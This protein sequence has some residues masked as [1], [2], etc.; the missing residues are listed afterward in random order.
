M[1]L[2]KD[3]FKVYKTFL[4]QFRDASKPRSSHSLSTVLSFNRQRVLL[5]SSMMVFVHALLALGGL[6]VPSAHSGTNLNGWICLA[7]GVFLVAA[8]YVMK[9]NPSTGNA[10][11]YLLFSL[12]LFYSLCL[13]SVVDRRNLGAAFYVF[14]VGLPQL[15]MLNPQIVTKICIAA[16]TGFIILCVWAKAPDLAGADAVNA[17]VYLLVSFVLNA[18]VQSTRLSDI[19][20]RYFIEHERD[21]DTLTG[22][23]TK[24]AF[25]LQVRHIMEQQDARGCMIVMD[26]NNFKHI[27]DC[28]GHSF[29][30]HVLAEVGKATQRIFRAMDVKGRFGGDEFTVFIPDSNDPLEVELLIAK[31]K[32]EISLIELPNPKEYVGGCTGFCFVSTVGRDYDTLFRSADANQ[33]EAK[34]A[35]H[36]R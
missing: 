2:L 11:A 7:S 29:G 19:S 27:N 32:H 25:E 20:Q 8:Y 30:D 21:T 1:E 33:Y 10:V 5:V 18:S 28:Y 22:L 14:L 35:F 4:M 26:L 23:L 17:C 3:I 9:F 16:T 34:R 24:H 6:F 13:G 31:W 36:C 15:F 12:C